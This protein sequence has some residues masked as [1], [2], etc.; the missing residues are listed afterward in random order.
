MYSI[1]F[2]FTLVSVLITKIIEIIQIFPIDF[3]QSAQNRLTE[4]YT[5]PTHTHTHVVST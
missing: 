5:V 4:S 2:N 1:S 3:D